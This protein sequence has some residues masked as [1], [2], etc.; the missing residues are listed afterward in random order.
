MVQLVSATRRCVRNMRRSGHDVQ[1]VCKLL[2]L[3]TCAVVHVLDANTDVI[4]ASEFQPKY[5]MSVTGR[6]RIKAG[7]RTT[8]IGKQALLR[9]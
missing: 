5:E 1:S 8:T 3:T 7:T 6:K 4:E 2:E 9:E